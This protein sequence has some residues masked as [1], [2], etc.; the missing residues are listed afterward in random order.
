MDLSPCGEAVETHRELV[1]PECDNVPPFVVT[2]LAPEHLL[3]EKVRTLLVR[4]KPRDLYD[5]WSMQN[6]TWSTLTR[7]PA[8]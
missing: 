1:S 2:L 8:S 3:A 4:G 7:R 5:L 6:S